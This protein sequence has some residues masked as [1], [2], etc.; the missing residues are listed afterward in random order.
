MA[1]IGIASVPGIS[2]H[3]A[4]MRGWLP[5]LASVLMLAAPALV[6]TQSAD[7]LS[8]YQD[9]ETAKASHD[10][11][12]AL[13][14]GDRALQLTQ[15]ETNDPQEVVSLLRNLGEF[16]AKSDKDQLAV[17]YYERALKLQESSLGVNHPDLVP[18]L[19]ALADLSI[20]DH[21][22]AD[23]D[24]LLQRIL[25]IERAAYGE[26]HENVLATLHQLRDLY[27][28]TNNPE[29]LARV[30]A[31]LQPPAATERGLPSLPGS[32]VASARHYK[33]GQGYATVRVFYGTN[34]ATTGEIKPA[35]YY[36]P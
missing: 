29:G 15:A 30:N 28:A 12:A 19:T 11:P 3:R 10:V 23:A 7:L 36:G 21:R 1:E 8:A 6:F 5:R 26:R 31:Q 32:A 33:Q 25:A 22:N 27:S 14:Y 24:A 2:R 16:A 4:G 20:K 18:T 17:Q 13:R 9:F 34:R 35:L